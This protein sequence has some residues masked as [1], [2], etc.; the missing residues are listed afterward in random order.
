M[1]IHKLVKTVVGGNG[2][3]PEDQHEDRHLSDSDQQCHEEE[4]HH[5]G[6]DHLAFGVTSPGGGH[7]HHGD[8]LLR[9]AGLAAL[10]VDVFPGKQGSAVHFLVQR[11][12]HHCV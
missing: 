11:V 3:L 12:L 6:E 7:W 9:L 8:V 1:N 10:V 5:E 2:A 4:E